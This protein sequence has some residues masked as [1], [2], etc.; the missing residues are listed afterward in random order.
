MDACNDFVTKVHQKE[1]FESKLEMKTE[2]I[3]LRKLKQL[4]N[5]LRE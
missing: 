2:K 4:K 3:E 5:L 1:I